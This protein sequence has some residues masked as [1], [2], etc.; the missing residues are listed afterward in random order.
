MPL[1]PKRV[2]YRKDPAGK[3]QGDGFAQSPDR[4]WR[5]RPAN[6]GARLDHQHPDGSRPR[7]AH[8]Q[9]E[10]Q[11]QILDPDFPGQ[12]RHLASAGNPHG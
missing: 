11:R 12:I 8:P 1:M 4:F 6:P 10:A 3:P 9:H 7:R 5:V 2:K